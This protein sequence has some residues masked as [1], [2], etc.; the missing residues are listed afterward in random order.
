MRENNCTP[1][2]KAPADK[3]EDRSTAAWPRGSLCQGV[4]M[5]TCE[6]AL[7]S[8]EALERQLQETTPEADVHSL[9]S[10]CPFLARFSPRNESWPQCQAAP[11]SPSAIFS[12]PSPSCSSIA[13]L[14]S[15]FRYSL[16]A[17]ASLSPVVLLPSS[18]CLSLVLSSSSSPLVVLLACT[19]YVVLLF[20]WHCPVRT[21]LSF[22][23][24]VCSCC[25][26]SLILLSSVVLLMSSSGLSVVLLFT[27]L[28][29][30]AAGAAAAH[31][32]NN[33]CRL[34]CLGSMLV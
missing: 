13:F 23:L 30:A 25:F 1:S 10:C 22:V 8:G 7:Q 29:E 24:L 3:R 20:F 15:F 17:A 5:T 27:L 21:S 26:P 12:V 32:D 18:S 2:G 28:S 6:R 14:L 4:N 31:D 16:T 34:S 19:P 9:S 33:S 11:A